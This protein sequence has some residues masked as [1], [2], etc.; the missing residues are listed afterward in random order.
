MDCKTGLVDYEM[1][2]LKNW[3]NYNGSN[4]LIKL[5]VVSFY[6]YMWDYRIHDIDLEKIKACANDLKDAINQKNYRLERDLGTGIE[7]IL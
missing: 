3:K 5:S 6:I 1:D 7:A 4:E 2:L